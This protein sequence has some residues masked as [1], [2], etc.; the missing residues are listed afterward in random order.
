VP[1][2]KFFKNIICLIDKPEGLTS[3]QVLG[4]VKKLLGVKKIGH[5]GTLDKF[6]S[7]LLVVGLNQGTKLLSY[8]VDDQ[9]R[10][11]GTIKLGVST[12]TDDLYGDIMRQESFDH[13]RED[14]IREVI[15]ALKGESWQRPPS[16]SALKIKGIRASDL[17]RQGEKLILAKRK[18]FISKLE[19]LEIDLKEG[20][21]ILDLTCS[22]GTY[23]RSL[24]RDIGEKL[25]I[26]A[27]LEKLRRLG[28]GTFKIEQAVSL[29]DLENGARDRKIIEPKGFILSPEQA[30]ANF[31]L[32]IIAD[33]AINKIKNGVFFQEDDI[34]SLKK[35]EE[36]PFLI[37]TQD[38]ILLAIAQVKIFEQWEI[39]YLNVFR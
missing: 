25:G 3:F 31:G 35:K 24:A 9:K 10:Y 28:S 22:K 4:R 11:L 1:E 7:G 16:F 12:E 37:M 27:H 13:L 39:E 15:F 20:R 34:I 8:L 14:S 33:S 2:E 32:I 36:Q 5:A 21:V 18:I 17:A 38:K 19:I 26:G 6:A 23:V 30:L 29:A